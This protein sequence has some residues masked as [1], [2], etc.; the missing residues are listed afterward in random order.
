MTIPKGYQLHIESWENDGNS[1]KTIIRSGLTEND[2]S[3]LIYLARFFEFKNNEE[4]I[5]NR[6]ITS[7]ALFN[8]LK[9]CQEKYPDVS[10]NIKKS[11]F[12]DKEQLALSENEFY[13]LMH[14]YY[15]RLLCEWILSNVEDENYKHYKQFDMFC[16]VVD[17]IKVFYIPLD[18][19]NVT[20]QWL[21]KK[22]PFNY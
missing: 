9:E 5:C 7:I 13:A 10:E 6:G 22:I 16:R 17:N 1:V 3:Y 14:D 18:A 21:N 4:D 2:V 11:L 15:H 12:V 20:S 8:I 19:K